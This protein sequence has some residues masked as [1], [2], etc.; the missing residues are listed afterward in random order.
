LFVFRFSQSNKLTITSSNVTFVSGSIKSISIKSK[1]LITHSSLSTIHSSTTSPDKSSSTE[2]KLFIQVFVI[3]SSS[4][5]G[6]LILNVLIP[7]QTN[8]KIKKIIYIFHSQTFRL[9]NLNKIPNKINKTKD[10]AILI[11]NCKCKTIFESQ[12][13]TK[14]QNKIDITKNQA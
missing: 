14:N 1:S 13:Q 5:L 3:S 7:D 9:L 11:N 10:A 4:K 2:T 12:N 6:I 8:N